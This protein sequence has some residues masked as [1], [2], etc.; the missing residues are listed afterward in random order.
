MAR[1]PA[2]FRISIKDKK[3]GNAV[4]VE[5]IEATGLWD[6]QRFRLRVNGREPERIK[7]ATLTETLDHLRKW[8]VKQKPVK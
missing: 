7:F 4:K 2:R 6:T 3:T 5:L 8:L 1:S